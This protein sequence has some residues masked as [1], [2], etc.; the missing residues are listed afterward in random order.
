M[1]FDVSLL[2]IKTNLVVYYFGYLKRRYEAAVLRNFTIVEHIKE[3]YHN[4]NLLRDGALEISSSRDP[5]QIAVFVFEYESTVEDTLSRILEILA[6]VFS[7][8]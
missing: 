5:A 3:V 7:I 8:C 1:A 6:E 2:V 4:I